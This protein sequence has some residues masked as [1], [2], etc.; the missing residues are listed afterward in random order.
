VGVYEEMMRL[1]PNVTVVL[2]SGYDEHEARRRFASEGP[3]AFLQKPFLFEELAA[4]L[5]DVMR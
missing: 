5:G 4:T 2:C 1:Q 3:I